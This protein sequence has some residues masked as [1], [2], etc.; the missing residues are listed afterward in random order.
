MGPQPSSRGNSTACE[1]WA[2]TES[3]SMGPQP[4][5]RG[6]R[7]GLESHAKRSKRLQW[8]RNLPVAEISHGRHQY[9]GRR[10]FFNGAATFQSRKSDAGRSSPTRTRLASM[11]PQ[12]S[13]RGN[14]APRRKPQ[15]APLASMGPQPSSRGNHAPSLCLL[16]RPLVASMGP[17][18]SSRGNLLLHAGGCEG[19]CGFNGAA[20][21]Q[22]RKFKAPLNPAHAHSASMGPQP[23]SRGNV[24]YPALARSEQSSF[25]GAATF[26]SRKSRSQL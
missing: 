20:T 12:P 26:Q 22:S 4:S 21:F 24:S 14:S 8:G 18:P 16:S 25:N 19:D 2:S 13:S 11:G 7:L 6:N 15:T 17:Q 5:S 9:R 3:S 1:A 10:H 23:S